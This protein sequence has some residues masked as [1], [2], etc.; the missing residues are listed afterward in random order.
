MKKTL[1]CLLALVILVGFASAEAVKEPLSIPVKNIYSAPSE[2]SNLILA[3]PIEVKLLDVG[4]DGNW[5][6][7]KISYAIGP[8]NYTY[9]G[10][11]EI[12]VASVVL[13]KASKASKVAKVDVPEE[14]IEE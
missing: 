12:P 11:T 2:D 14:V 8:F 7:V 13:E 10:W 5:Y 6:K 9:I 4:A 3:I 1:F